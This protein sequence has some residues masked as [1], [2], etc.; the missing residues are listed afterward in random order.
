MVY[1]LGITSIPRITAEINSVG[2]RVRVT[3]AQSQRFLTISF[4]CRWYVFQNPITIIYMY[5]CMYYWELF[6]DIPILIKLVC[7]ESDD[8]QTSICVQGR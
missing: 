3:K 6:G 5:N 7:D 1:V 4:A 8:K 2:M